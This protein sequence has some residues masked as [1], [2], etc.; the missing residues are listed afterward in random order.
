MKI[1]IAGAGAIGFHLAQLLSHEN[2]DIVLIDNNQEVLEYAN[3][4]LDVLVLEGDSSSLSILN[5]AQ[6]DRAQLLI[7]VTTSEK[8]NLITAMLAKKL[9]A[10]TTIARVN[11]QEYLTP[12]QKANF[13]EMGVDKLISPN[14]LAAQ[15]ISRLLQRCSLTDIF[16]FEKG[17][18]SVVGVTLDS[19]SALIDRRVADIAMAYPD[20]K[21]QF[22]AVLRGHETIMPRGD[23]IL[24]RNDHLY[25][26]NQK[27][28]LDDILQVMGKEERKVKHL[29][30]VGGK[31][32][33]FKT[34]QLLEKDYHITL[35]EESKMACNKLVESLDHSLIIKGDPSNVTLLKEEGLSNMD[36]FI[37]VTE[38]SETNIITSLMAEELGVYKTIALVDNV[39]YTRISQ[40][41]GIDTIINKKIIAANNIFRFVRQGK[42]EAIASLHGVDVEVIEFVVHRRNKLIKKPIKDLHFP[43]EAIIGGVIRNERSLIPNGDLILELQDKVI[44]V[45][46]PVALKKVEA[47]FR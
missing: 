13:L 2:Q 20:L 5:E 16:D 30:I 28:K 31:A 45:T 8:N 34:A 1:I 29:M 12:D 6:V 40:N 44:V 4:I 26:V 10:R 32:M 11:N 24:R 47:L 19:E 9:G 38:N 41:I 21:F 33:G 37:A 43:K 15:E 17:Q 3:S 36:A 35:V 39:D 23:T 22:V 7:S 25:L 18:L 14:R 42:I 46:K 27:E